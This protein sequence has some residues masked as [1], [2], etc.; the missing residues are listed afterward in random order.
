[1]EVDSVGII[2]I[3]KTHTSKNIHKCSK[4]PQSARRKLN[5]HTKC[6]RLSV[7]ENSISKIEEIIFLKQTVML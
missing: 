7:T 2:A 1:M 6:G 4:N 3:V 5:Y